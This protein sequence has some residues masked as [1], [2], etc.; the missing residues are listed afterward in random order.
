M[1][2]PPEQPDRREATPPAGAPGQPP[3]AQ[4]PYGAGQW[5]ER[6]Y[7]ADGPPYGAAEPPGRPYGSA[8]HPGGYGAMGPILRYGGRW[9]RLIAAIIDGL[10]VYALTLLATAPIIGHG[11]VYGARQIAADLVAAVI[12]FLYYVLQHG[13]WGQTLGKRAMNLRVVRESD[14]GPIGYGQAAWRL[15]FQYL[16]SL[17]TCGIGGIV[18]VAWILWDPRRQALH[19]KV[20]K[21]V[22]VQTEP[23]TPDPYKGR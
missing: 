2:E 21:T 1:T 23:G 22:V 9:R 13:T 16:L 11:T 6:P 7:G 5:S 19:D 18:D 14:G 3:P 20:A 8:D 15:L 10:I 4:T 12:A 17:L